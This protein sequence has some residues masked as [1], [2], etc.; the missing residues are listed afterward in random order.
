MKWY[1][2]AADQGLAS[3]QYDLGVMFAN[4]DGVPKDSAEA[5]KWYRKAATQGIAPAQYSLGIMFANGDGVPIDEIEGLAW[6]NIAAA[7]GFQGAIGNKKV[8]ENR[9]S[10]E[11]TLA[12]QRRS[13]EIVRELETSKVP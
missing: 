9:L 10:P 13:E 5:V 3:A 11:A 8:L 2:R 1:R 4:G 12:A 7:S 6:T